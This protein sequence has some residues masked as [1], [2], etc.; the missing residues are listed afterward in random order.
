ML[1]LYQEKDLE[2]SKYWFF[3]ESAFIFFARE[4]A[5][6]PWEIYHINTIY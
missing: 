4:V 2:E 6:F 5:R 3:L 1:F